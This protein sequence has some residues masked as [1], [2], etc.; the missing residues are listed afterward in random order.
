MFVINLQSLST[1]GTVRMHI[2]TAAQLSTQP[3]TARVTSCPVIC[4]KLPI[5]GIKHA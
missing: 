1:L 3:Q 4:F 5:S 2:A